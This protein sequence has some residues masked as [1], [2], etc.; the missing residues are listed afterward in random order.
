M[1]WRLS[2]GRPGRHMRPPGRHVAPR[3][4]RPWPGGLVLQ[5]G[6]VAVVGTGLAVGFALL[7]ASVGADLPQQAAPLGP[8][9]TTWQPPPPTGRSPATEPPPPEPTA[10]GT[11]K[12][13]A[14]AE[15][16]TPQ[17]GVV[18]LASWS[19]GEASRTPRNRSAVSSSQPHAVTPGRSPTE[20]TPELSPPALSPEPSDS[21]PADDVPSP[22]STSPPTLSAPPPPLPSGKPAA[23]PACPHHRDQDRDRD[24][25][26]RDRGRPCRRCHPDAGNPEHRRPGRPQVHRRHVPEPAPNPDP[27]MPPGT[28]LIVPPAAAEEAGGGPPI[29]NPNS[30]GEEPLDG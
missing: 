13:P 12:P 19:T 23:E 15:P 29:P 18:E 6:L 28:K 8:P 30:D 20:P 21:P 4:R 1:R 2:G 14:A 10:A 26:G 24:R 9:P 22:P 5:S 27:Q 25:P 16:A 11:G 3:A 7:Y 17:P